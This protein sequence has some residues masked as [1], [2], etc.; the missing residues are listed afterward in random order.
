MTHVLGVAGLAAIGLNG[1]SQAGPELFARDVVSAANYAAGTVTPG[2]IV[3]LYPSN[4]GPLNLAES[5]LDANGRMANSVGA[6][7]VLFDGIPAPI[8]YSVR[9]QVGAIV[10]YGLSDRKTTNVVVEYEGV[11][12]TPVTLPVVPVAPA[13]FTLDS[14]GKGQAAMLNETGCCNS[15]RSPAMRGS[16]AQLYA[17]GAGQTTPRG[18]DGL[19]SDYPRLADYPIP[20][21]PVTVTVGGIPAEILYAGEAPLH[22]TGTF[23]VNFRVP[24]D[25]PLGDAIPLVLTVGNTR[26]SD[27]VTMAIRSSVQRILVV[28]RD[29]AIRQS[30]TKILRSAGYEVLLAPLAQEQPVDL[31]ICDLAA[32]DKEIPKEHR[33]VKIIATSAALSPDVLKAADM[34]GAQA[35]LTKPL[36]AERVLRKV[37]ELLAARP[38]P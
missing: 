11:R 28:D 22:V 38:F 25:A 24:P 16:V 13:L 14:S 9:G 31:M 6:T 8:F 33:H 2:E 30:L 3:V 19:F 20:Q 4:A 21:L 29:A 23:V 32:N 35:V 34:L 10:P 18:T 27:A 1:Q 17:V 12:S 5:H 37:R 26:S 7:R 36:S 15:A